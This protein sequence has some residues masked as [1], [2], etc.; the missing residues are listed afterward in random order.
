[1]KPYFELQSGTC[2]PV[3]QMPILSLVLN[4]FLV[5]SFHP[6]L[7]SFCHGSRHW[8]E[9]KMAKLKKRD[10]GRYQKSVIVENLKKVIP[11][12]RSIFG[13]LAKD[14]YINKIEVIVKY[15]NVQMNP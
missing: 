5:N 8:K 14:C 12:K 4:A 2:T 13:G 7:Y 10:D 1:M 15:R 9:V 11:R 6:I 3:E